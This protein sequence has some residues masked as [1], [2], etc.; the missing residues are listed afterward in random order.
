MSV[1]SDGHGKGAGNMAVSRATDAALCA[2]SVR[3]SVEVDA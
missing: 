2:V 3:N 1:R